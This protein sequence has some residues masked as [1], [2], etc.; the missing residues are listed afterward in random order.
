MN[1]IIHDDI[2]RNCHI[3]IEDA[4]IPN[5]D[6]VCKSNASANDNALPP[7]NL[8]SLFSPKSG[9]RVYQVEEI[10]FSFVT[11]RKPMSN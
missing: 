10:N 8:A 4:K 9:A 2:V 5:F 1:K 7:F 11:L 6:I 3:L